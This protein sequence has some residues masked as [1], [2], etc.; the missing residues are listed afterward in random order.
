MIL[1][2]IT[3][4]AN[5]ESILSKGLYPGKSVD[6]TNGITVFYSPYSDSPIRDH[7]FLTDNVKYILNN[8]AGIDWVNDNKPYLLEVDCRRLKLKNWKME[9]S[10]GDHPHEFVTKNK[11]SHKRIKVVKQ[12]DK[13]DF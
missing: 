11:I 13:S 7:V 1:Y 9:Y 6:K 5:L 2:H 4:S 12:L 8:Q 3:P 10:N